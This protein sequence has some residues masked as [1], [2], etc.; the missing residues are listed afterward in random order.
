MSFSLKGEHFLVYN[1]LNKYFAMC[2]KTLVTGNTG[3]LRF[4]FIRQNNLSSR[5]DFPIL[6]LTG[7]V[8]TNR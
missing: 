2:K 3:L 8:K 6:N 7:L 4:R 1:G 5:T